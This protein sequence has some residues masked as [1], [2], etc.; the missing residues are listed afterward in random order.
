MANR[1]RLWKSLL[2]CVKRASRGDS[3]Q[4]G[5]TQDEIVA[6]SAELDQYLQVLDG[7]VEDLFPERADKDIHVV[8]RIKAVAEYVEKQVLPSIKRHS[9][10]NITAI[11]EFQMGPNVQ[12]KAVQSA[13]I[14]LFFRYPTRVVGPS[15]KN[16]ISLSEE[17]QYYNFVQKYKNTYSANKAHALHNF[18]HLERMFGSTIPET[19]PASR[20]GH[21]ADSTMQIL[22]MLA[23]DAKSPGKKTEMF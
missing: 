2:E 5:P 18:L 4:K 9:P 12:T 22:G 17:G 23:Q 16:K 13:L 11:I 3:A 15:L 21:I 7:G 6:L 14:A 20:R 10:K 19:K 1:V 8:E